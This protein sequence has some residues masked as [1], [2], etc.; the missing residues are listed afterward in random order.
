MLKNTLVALILK[1]FFK[2]YERTCAV[3]TTHT[4]NN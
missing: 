3:D 1:T 2:S 4:E